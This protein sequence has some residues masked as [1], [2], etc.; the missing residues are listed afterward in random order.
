MDINIFFA[1]IRAA[2]A[3]LGPSTRLGPT[4]LLTSLRSGLRP[5]LREESSHILMETGLYLLGLSLKTCLCGDHQTTTHSCTPSQLSYTSLVFSF[6]VYVVAYKT[7]LQKASK[8]KFI[9]INSCSVAKVKYH[10]KTEA[11]RA[12]IKC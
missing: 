3:T 7:Y 2:L 12:F 8:R 10:R 4:D 1:R 5:S 9:D 6:T 11:I